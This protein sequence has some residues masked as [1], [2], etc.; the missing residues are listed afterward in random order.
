[1]TPGEQHVFEMRMLEDPFLREACEGFGMLHEDGI[2]IASVTRK[3]SRLLPEAEAARSGGPEKPVWRYMVAAGVLLIA[4][5]FS[6]LRFGANT[7]SIRL[8]EASATERAP[9]VEK[10]SGQSQPEGKKT[11]AVMTP[12][13]EAAEP[14][15]AQPAV[16]VI[17]K[18][19][20]AFPPGDTIKSG[21][22][23]SIS[24][25]G[26]EAD[27]WQLPRE[28][29]RLAS[30]GFRDGEVIVVS[31]HVIRGKKDSASAGNIVVIVK[32]KQTG[33]TIEPGKGGRPATER[34][35]FEE[36]LRRA[37]RNT[38]Q[39][40]EFVE[41]KILRN[42]RLEDLTPGEQDSLQKEMIRRKE[43]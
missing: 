26:A 24:G 32:E 35:S 16:S 6:Y 19:R 37:T 18:K 23:G 38:L 30:A 13:G 15:T 3:L 2:A 21:Q 5:F 39:Y 17:S 7:D 10:H 12:P 1:M 20:D 9:V 8:K 42:G 11:T 43:N 27:T 22:A 29:D 41:F 28:T 33:D 14:G 25:R 31:D 34:M 4:A 40:G 36:Y